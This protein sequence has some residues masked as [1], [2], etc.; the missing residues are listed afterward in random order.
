MSA[1]E[2]RRLVV[3]MTGASGA[4]YG[5]RLLEALQ[6]TGIEV[7][8]V[9]SKPAERT[10]AEETDHSVG[11][12]KGLARFTHQIGNIGA[13]IASGSFRSAGMVVAPCS[14]RTASA[15]AYCLADNLLTRAADVVLK[16]RRRLVLLVRETPLHTGHLKALLGAAEAGAIIM[17][18][19]P[20]F[21]ARPKSLAD[22]VDHTVGRMLDLFD[23][24]HA[25]VRRW[26]ED[27]P[28]QD[29]DDSA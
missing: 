1:T 14:V 22:L 17:P 8:L 15:V 10:I 3:G 28:A 18:P 29:Q 25:L 27:Q 6:A 11:Y 9:M 12:V 13:S 2:S 23:I 20:A 4:I 21:Y 24:E 16:E 19:V 7:H 5:V 26:G